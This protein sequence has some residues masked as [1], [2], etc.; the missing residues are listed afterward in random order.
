[1]PHITETELREIHACLSVALRQSV[2]SDDQIV[3]GH[4]RDAHTIA[5]VCLK[6]SADEPSILEL[7]KAH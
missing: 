5:D 6:R 3:M 1:M 2:P 7:A 4:V